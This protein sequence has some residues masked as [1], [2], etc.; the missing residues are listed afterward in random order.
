MLVAT[1]ILGLLVTILLGVLALN[2]EAVAFSRSKMDGYDLD[3]VGLGM[4]DEDIWGD[5]S[6]GDIRPIDANMKLEYRKRHRD[7]IR[8]VSYTHLRAHET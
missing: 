5:D 3:E 7:E 2:G 1:I 8:A 6:R 4:P